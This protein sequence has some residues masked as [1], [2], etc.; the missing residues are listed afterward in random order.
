MQSVSRSGDFTRHFFL[1]REIFVKKLGTNAH[2]N[3]GGTSKINNT[4]D[5]L[6]CHIIGG[7]QTLPENGD[8]NL[9]CYKAGMR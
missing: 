7:P 2:K 8:D 1:G 6:Y 9:E 3:R 5:R 4:V